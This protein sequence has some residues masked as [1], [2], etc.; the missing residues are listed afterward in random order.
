MFHRNLICRRKQI[1]D[2]SDWCE[3]DRHSCSGQVAAAA[4]E[5]NI[6]LQVPAP[7]PAIVVRGD[8]DETDLLE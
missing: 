6:T 3:F 5:V 8:L 1:E 2:R 4:A 7:V